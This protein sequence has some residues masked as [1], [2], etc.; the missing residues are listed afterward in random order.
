MMRNS[1]GPGLEYSTFF[2]GLIHSMCFL[3]RFNLEH[4]DVIGHRF[5]LLGALL[6]K[7]LLFLAAALRS[8]KLGFHQVFSFSHLSGG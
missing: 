2:D 4:V 6:V 7:C 5:D 3:T 1:A 8:G